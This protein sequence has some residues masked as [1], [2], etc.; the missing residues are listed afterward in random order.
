MNTDQLT[1]VLISKISRINIEFK[2]ASDC[3]T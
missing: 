3:D 2:N 1:D